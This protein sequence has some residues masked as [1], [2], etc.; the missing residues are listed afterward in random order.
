MYVC[1]YV[2]CALAASLL[3][4][5]DNATWRS[6]WKSISGPSYTEIFQ[7]V[8]IVFVDRIFFELC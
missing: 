6:G 1:M 4:G 3:I 2:C 8:Y 7:V 5:A